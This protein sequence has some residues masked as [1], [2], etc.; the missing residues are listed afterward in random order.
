MLWIFPS[1]VVGVR[2]WLLAG[3]IATVGV[4]HG[5]S[6]PPYPSPPPVPCPT[7][8]AARGWI[9]GT[10]TSLEQATFGCEALGAASDGCVVGALDPWC[11]GKPHKVVVSLAGV[12][13]EVS[14]PANGAWQICDLAPGHYDLTVCSSRG[15]FRCSADASTLVQLVEVEPRVQVHV[16]QVF[17]GR[18][19]WAGQQLSFTLGNAQHATDL[20]LPPQIALAW[21]EDGKLPHAY[22]CE[23]PGS[24]APGCSRCDATSD[25]GQAAL[26]LA[27]VAIVLGRRR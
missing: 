18:P 7:R 10:V 27:V 3:V 19:S 14:A 11:G 15:D 8:S 17:V 26:W 13:R 20:T 12:R 21:T 1:C 22:L 4:A 2:L 23:P 16:D 24:P 9:R 5:D 25:P 6:F